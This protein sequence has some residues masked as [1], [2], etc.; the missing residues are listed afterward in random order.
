MRPVCQGRLLDLATE[1]WERM[2]DE[3]SGDLV[4]GYLPTSVS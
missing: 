3:F 2:T 1:L 4:G